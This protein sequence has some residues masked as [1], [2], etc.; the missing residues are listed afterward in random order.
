[1]SIFSWNK[2]QEQAKA[3]QAP[4]EAPV[5]DV[6]EEAA[7]SVPSDAEAMAN[8]ERIQ[9]EYAAQKAADEAA[10]ANVGKMQSEAAAEEK[11]EATK[12]KHEAEE[13]KAKA[14]K[15]ALRTYTVKRGDTLSEIGQ[16]FG[17]NWRE[18]AKLNKLDNP[19]LIFP[20][21]E[22]KIPND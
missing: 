7:A 17:V 6:A 20:G 16:K 8:V 21:Q 9:A 3:E 19:D 5:V 15:K 4:V 18:I 22:F 1:M 2:D 10:I 11:A 14:Q 13:K 12:L